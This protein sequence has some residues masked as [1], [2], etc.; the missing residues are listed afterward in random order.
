MSVQDSG[1]NKV[2]VLALAVLGIMLVNVVNVAVKGGMDHGVGMDTFLAGM[3]D[4][5][6]VFINTDLVVGLWFP[7]AWI[8]LRERGGRTI[9]TVAWIW[10]LLWWGN[11]VLAAYVLRAVRQANGDWSLFFLGRSTTGAA[12]DRSATASRSPYRYAWFAAAA[13]AAV[14]IAISLSRVGFAGLP[15]FGYIAGF[16][17]IVLA[18]VLLGLNG[19]EF[20]VGRPTSRTG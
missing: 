4:P 9:E 19:A 1:M 10:L 8:L 11:I 5:W 20:L 7:A 14:Y 13:A 15:A 12:I 2:R 18:L 6:Q 17:P 3:G 16:T